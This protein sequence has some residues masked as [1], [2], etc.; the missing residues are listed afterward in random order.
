MLKPILISP[1]IYVLELEEGK[2][3]VGIT[4]NFNQRLAQ[5][6]SG[7]GAKWTRLYKPKKVLEI[8]FENATEQLEHETTLKYIELHGKENVK[9][10]FLTR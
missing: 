4:L 9:G 6:L 3:Y 10:G 2:I 8:I 7:E 5:H 1:V